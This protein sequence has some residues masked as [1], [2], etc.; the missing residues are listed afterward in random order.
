M[1]AEIEKVDPHKKVDVGSFRLDGNGNVK[2]NLVTLDL[3]YFSFLFHH[4]RIVLTKKFEKSGML[5]Q[6]SSIF[7]FEWLPSQKHLPHFVADEITKSHLSYV[8]GTLCA[9]RAASLRGLSPFIQYHPNMKKIMNDR[10]LKGYGP[11]LHQRN[12]RICCR[13]L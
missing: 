12:E 7:L 1:E 9:K 2:Q 6:C 8:L 10:L 3:S 13:Q 5:H 11:S 4:S